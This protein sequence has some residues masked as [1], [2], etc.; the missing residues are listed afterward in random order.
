[1]NG[2]YEATAFLSIASRN[3]HQISYIPNQLLNENLHLHTPRVTDSIV[4]GLLE[5][6]ESSMFPVCEADIA[7]EGDVI[8]GKIDD[9]ILLV[10]MSVFVI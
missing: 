10:N 5:V 1:M 6:V 8:D 7:V 4:H 2:S 9:V 3:I